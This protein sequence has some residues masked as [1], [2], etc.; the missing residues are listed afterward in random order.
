MA[1]TYGTLEKVKRELNKPTS[2]VSDDTR[3]EEMI[4]DVSDFI[5]LKLKEAG[6][7]DPETDI[8]ADPTIHRI[9]SEIVAWKFR[10]SRGEGQRSFSVAAE[11]Q[12][13][14][15]TG[16]QMALRELQTWIN[17]ITGTASSQTGVFEIRR[18]EGSRDF[19]PLQLM[20]D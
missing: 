4:L 8:A 2:E 16:L 13:D 5:N 11:R 6:E 12:M 1:S 19:T 10:L 3:L 18:I 17:V 7:M 14:R 9:A 15:V 20:D